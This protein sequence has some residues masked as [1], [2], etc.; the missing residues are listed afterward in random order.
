[1]RT[2]TGAYAHAKDAVAA[3]G[4]T[5]TAENTSG[6]S[7]GSDNG[8]PCGFFAERGSDHMYVGVYSSKGEAGIDSEIADGVVVMVRV[9]GEG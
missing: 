1:M 6:C 7:S 3:A 8:P 4:L 2:L 9:Y 5:I